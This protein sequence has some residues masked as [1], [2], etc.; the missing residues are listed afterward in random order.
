MSYIVGDSDDRP[1]GRWEVLAVGE[2]F[3]VKKITVKPGEVLSLQYH[4]HRAEHW[5]ILSGEAEVTV[6]E[7]VARKGS[8]ETVFIPIGA[9]HRIANPG[10]S[11]LVFIEV[12]TGD[13]LAEDDIVRLEDRYGRTA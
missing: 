13:R 7:T 2:G 9:K 3:A 6:D 12:Q 4:H 8:D 11:E 1:W 5:V 10:S